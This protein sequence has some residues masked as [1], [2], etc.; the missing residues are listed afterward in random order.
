[1]DRFVHMHVHSDYSFQDG[2]CPIPLLV[3]RVAEMGQPAVAL[4]DH[5]NLHGMIEFL[6]ACE[7]AGIRGIP[8]CEFYVAPGDRRE[9]AP[10]AGEGREPKYFH[11]TVLAQDETGWRN[12]IQLASAAFLEGFYHRPRIDKALLQAHAQGLIGLSGCLQGEIAQCLLQGGSMEEAVRLVESYQS[13]FGRDNFFL[14]I[15]FHGLEDDL[16]L[17]ARLLELARRTGAPLVI[18]NDA[19]YVRRSDHEL[20]EIR[21][22]IQTN[23]P[24]PE[25]VP[26]GFKT[27]EFYLKSRLE[28][29]ETFHQMVDQ[30]HVPMTPAEIEGALDMTL[31]IA[32][33]CQVRLPPKA[34]KLPHFP[35]PPGETVDT[36]F[37]KE[38]RR[39]FETERLPYLRAMAEAG[40]LR[41][42]LERYFER[43][44]YEIEMIRRMGFAGY[45][46]IVADFIG[47]AKAQGIPVGP[48]R[49][50]VAGSLVAYALGITEIDPLQYDLLF[51]RFLNPDRITLPDIDVDFCAQRRD[52]VI[53]YV[54]QKYGADSVAQII[55][56]QTM[57]ARGA[58]RDVGRVL[59]IDLGRVD[60][61]AKMVPM[62]PGVTLARV[63]ETDPE[64]RRLAERGAPEEQ[65]LLRY[66][67]ALEGIAKNSGTHAAGIVIAPGRLLDYV[68]LCRSK[69]GD[70][71]TQFDMNGLERLGLLKMD[72][73]GLMNLTIIDDCLRRIERRTG[74][75]I[76]IHR[77]PL[78]DPQVMD[79]FCEGRT[80][81]IFQFESSG[82]KDLLRRFKPR[83]F[84]DL[85]AL[86]A[87]F[88]PGPM[89]MLDDFIERRHGRKPIEYELP[90]LEPILA[91]TYGVIVYQ[92]QAMQIAA[93]VA[94]FTMA[95]ADN[96][97]R[98]MAKKKKDEMDRLRPRFVEGAVAR[99]VPREKA[100]RLFETLEKFAEY[101]FNKSHSCAY[102]LIAYQTAYLKVHYPVYYM[103]ALL[104]NRMHHQDELTLYL[105]ECRE[106]GLQVLPPS[107]N[108][109]E[110]DFTIID[111]R[112]I[113]FGLA[114]IKGVGP[115]VV[116]AILE[117]RQ[118]AGR[119]VSFLHFVESVDARAVNRR[120]IEALIK[121]GA[122]DEFGYTRRALMEALDG[123]LDRTARQAVVGRARAVP[124]A[125]LPGLP[126][127]AT[128]PVVNHDIPSKPEWDDVQ[129][130]QYEREALGVYLT[131]HPC[132][133]YEAE[134][135]H[136][137]KQSVEQLDV[138][139]DGKTVRLAG[140]LTSVDIRK[141]KRGVRYAM[142]RMEDLTGGIDVWVPPQTLETLEDVLREDLPV[143]LDGVLEADEGTR[144]VMAQEVWTLAQA[145]E[146]LAQRLRIAVRLVGAPPSA[147]ER[148]AALFQEY[149]GTT[150]V[151]LE[152]RKPGKFTAVVRLPHRVRVHEDLLRQLRDLFGP[153]SVQV[154]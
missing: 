72:F 91:E 124:L 93:Q 119:F 9:R 104:S 51:E 139:L 130:L 90:E 83:R 95:E 40:Q 108:E 38:V 109:S 128:T 89:Q 146:R 41:R 65:K 16:Y 30:Y 75:R 26:L 100:E 36:Y 34:Y 35:V 42:P 52:Q 22:R 25:P 43:L 12:L 145:R 11:L 117:A 17:N 23:T 99:G 80:N 13:I 81:G 49:G 8:G 37:E 20:Q 152:L 58:I 47:W 44:D 131:G 84:E 18:T 154:V 53:A 133:R 106:M 114:G 92:E 136:Y 19:H 4:T 67:R 118:R 61:I 134:L 62:G 144:R 46:L 153:D 123:V 122:L 113:R 132:E 29:A 5:G 14:E 115:A 2:L 7:Q 77:I 55:T 10:G 105:R 127:V 148:L 50:S 15:Q 74:Q 110:A 59:R 116:Q 39:R 63:L 85:I 125:G 78:D 121:A 101:A 102:A 88:R 143:V 68:P 79:L 6:E 97:R 64:L 76:D 147:P 66:A 137:R 129:K 126:G 31:A 71:V 45:F 150:V 73:L 86:N 28:M 112:T 70:V 120:S 111:D 82:M 69:E 142:L 48:G 24:V 54:R 87:L 151:E 103:A 60:R 141:S 107:I 140:I 27:P 56:F 3:R 32:E 98:A 135:T 149:A 57:A 33:R 94:G 1:M 21:I 96:L 138:A